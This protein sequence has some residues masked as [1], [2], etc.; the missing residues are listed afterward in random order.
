MVGEEERRRITEELNTNI[1][2]SRKLAMSPSPD[3]GT[4]RSTRRTYGLAERPE[5]GQRGGRRQG[6]GY[7]RTDV[8]SITVVRTAAAVPEWRTFCAA[9]YL[10]QVQRR[11]KF[12]EAHGNRS[13]PPM[14]DAR[15][16]REDQPVRRV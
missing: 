1:L 3:P 15:D 9:R 16:A 4:G 13:A 11:I 2:V 14:K 7:S 6:A 10:E 8:Q 12:T 5:E